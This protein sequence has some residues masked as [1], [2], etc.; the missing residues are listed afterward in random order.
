MIFRTRDHNFKDIFSFEPEDNPE[1]DIK[2][3]LKIE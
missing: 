1:L 2:I 3:D